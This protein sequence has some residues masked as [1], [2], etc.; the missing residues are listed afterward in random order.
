VVSGAAEVVVCVHSDKLGTGVSGQGTIDLFSSLGMHDEFETPFGLH[1]SALAGLMTQRYMHETETTLR[2]LAAVNVSNRKWAQL[3][4]NAMFRKDLTIE[5]VLSAKV[6]SEPLTTLS[7]N[8]FADGGS[9][10]VVTS[11]DRAR[12]LTDRPAYV[13]GHGSRVT[14]YSVTQDTDIS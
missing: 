6:L 11:E 5:E 2:Q 10:F 3:N 12:E 8:V 14:H 9:A 1:Y 4:P 7:S 13:L